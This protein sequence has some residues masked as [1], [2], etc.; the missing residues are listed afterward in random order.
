MSPSASRPRDALST[1]LR[2]RLDALSPTDSVVVI[3]ALAWQSPAEPRK[4]RLT[5]EQRQ[6]MIV[7]NPVCMFQSMIS[8][9]KSSG[10]RCCC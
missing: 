8:P 5:R 9:S 3:L 6:A 1:H 7:A 2:S 10:D 4:K